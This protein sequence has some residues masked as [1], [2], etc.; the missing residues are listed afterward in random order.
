M[1]D[2]VCILTDSTCSTLST[3]VTNDLARRVYG[4]REKLAAGFTRRYNVS[5]LV[6]YES[7]GDLASA[8]TREKQ[9]KAGPRLQKLSLVSEFNPRWRDLYDTI[10][11]VSS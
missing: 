1:N 4:H 10:L 5:R 9:M 2:Y 7:F 11:A 6:Y 3:G 8:L